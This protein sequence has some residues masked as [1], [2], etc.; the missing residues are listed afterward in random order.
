MREGGVAC[1]DVVSFLECDE[2]DGCLCAR[3]VRLVGRKKKKVA[4]R[5]GRFVSFSGC[6]KG[7]QCL[8]FGVYSFKWA[9][10][11][12]QTMRE[13]YDVFLARF[14]AARWRAHDSGA[15]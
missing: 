9:V 12:I 4:S 10:C 5:L 2:R 7:V 1:D 3:I 6:F 13:A 8:L 15:P 11:M 14:T